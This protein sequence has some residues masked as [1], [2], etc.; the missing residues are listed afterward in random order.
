MMTPESRSVRPATATVAM[1]SRTVDTEIAEEEDSAEVAEAAADEVVVEVAVAVV[2]LEVAEATRTGTTITA[3]AEA[4][5]ATVEVE[6]ATEVAAM[7]TAGITIRMEKMATKMEIAADSAV[8][9]VEAAE[10]V[11]VVE[12]VEAGTLEVAITEMRV[13]SADEAAAVDSGLVEK[14]TTITTKTVKSK[15]TNLGSCTFRHLRPKMRMKSLAPA[16]APVS[17][18]TNLTILR[19]T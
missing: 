5:M 12:E 16:S 7:D 14:M 2:V 4:E 6:T 18:L 10:D 19:S 11:A 15:W 17:T 8:G 1:T 9:V 13:D 3:T